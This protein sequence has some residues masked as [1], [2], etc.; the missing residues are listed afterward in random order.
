MFIGR[1]TGRV[2]AGADR[3][4]I[5]MVSE[6]L[7]CDTLPAREGLCGPQGCASQ[8]NAGCY[9]RPD[10][11]TLVAVLLL[12]T[13]THLAEKPRSAEKSYS[14][15]IIVY[16]WIWNHLDGEN[17]LLVLLSSNCISLHVLNCSQPSSTARNAGLTTRSS[18][19]CQRDIQQRYGSLNLQHA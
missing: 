10:I 17:Q 9:P 11:C 1:T 2:A 4:P 18:D 3:F 16:S 15:Q 8:T 5:K 19:Q 6:L 13:P 12:L 14:P 7:L